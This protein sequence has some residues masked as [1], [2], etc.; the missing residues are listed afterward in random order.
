MSTPIEPPLPAIITDIDNATDNTLI[1]NFTPSTSPTPYISSYTVSLTAPARSVLLDPVTSSP[2]TFTGLV[3]GITYTAIV[4]ANYCMGNVPSDPASMVALG[5]ALPVT[6][7]SAEADYEQITVTFDS[8]ATLYSDLDDY[9]I[10]I[11]P[12]TGTTKTYTVTP[13][14]EYSFSK[15]C[16]GLEQLMEYTVQVETRGKGTP[17]YST[18]I[19]SV[20]TPI[21]IVSGDLKE[22]S[23]ST[24]PFLPA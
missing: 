20:N 4:T 8:S 6:I 15:I 7:S 9:L 5:N 22:I 21:V 1:V 14:A 23:D 11:T 18:P 13:T 10:I 17:I 12:T 2:A 3:A 16:T 24:A 19:A